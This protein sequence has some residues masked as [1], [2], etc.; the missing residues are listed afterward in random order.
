MRTLLASPCGP[1]A[2]GLLSLAAV[3]AGLALGA[4]WDQLTARARAHYAP[5]S[6][7]R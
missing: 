5:G 7:R 6:H 3:W 2:A 1:I 4:A